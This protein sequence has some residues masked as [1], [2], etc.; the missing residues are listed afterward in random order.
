MGNGPGE[1]LLSMFQ[2]KEAL[3]KY[4]GKAGRRKWLECG[5]GICGRAKAEKSISVYAY[6]GGE[7]TVSFLSFGRKHF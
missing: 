2:A 3:R 4:M 7:G 1:V 5:Q 6:S